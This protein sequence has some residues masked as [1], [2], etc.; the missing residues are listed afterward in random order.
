MK[1]DKSPPLSPPGSELY[2]YSKVGARLREQGAAKVREQD[3]K[4]TDETGRVHHPGTG[5]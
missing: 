4:N 1:N 3:R 5:K 2:P